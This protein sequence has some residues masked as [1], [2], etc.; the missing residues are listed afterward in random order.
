MA[1]VNEVAVIKTTAGE[2]VVEFWP[3]VAP[4]TVANFKKLASEGFY[5]GTAFHRIVKGFMIQG[6]DPL[7]K[8][9]NAQE[10]WGTGGPGHKVKAEFNEKP[11]V[12]G[13]LSMA[14]S[15]NP[16]SAGSQFFICLADARFLDRQYTA[17]GRLILGDD[18]LTKIGDTPTTRS[19]GGE[20]S[21]PT[22]RIGVESV[23]IV[24]GDS[25]K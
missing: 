2:L 7:T 3:E 8:D 19:N 4:L 14:R 15:Q 11:H 21:K 6:G 1:S 24:P 20:A 16:D 17:F 12:R 9:E 22:K 5:D 10:R 13:V 23:K 18:V 25:I